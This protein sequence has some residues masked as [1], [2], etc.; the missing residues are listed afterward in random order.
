MR[1]VIAMNQ[2]R[3]SAKDLNLDL[4]V[5]V[6]VIRTRPSDQHYFWSTTIETGRF[7]S[8]CVGLGVGCCMDFVSRLT[9]RLT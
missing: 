1:G 2:R 5:D 6:M 7:L 4:G 8:H 9:L 3:D